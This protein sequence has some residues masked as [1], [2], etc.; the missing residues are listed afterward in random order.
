M[1]N[2]IRSTTRTRCKY[3]TTTTPA[4][5][6]E[7]NSE[8]RNPPPVPTSN[9]SLHSLG[10][11][12]VL[13]ANKRRSPARGPLEPPRA[14]IARVLIKRLPPLR[15]KSLV[16]SDQ[17][18]SYFVQVYD[19]FLTHDWRSISSYLCSSRGN[20]KGRLSLKVTKDSYQDNTE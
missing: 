16:I 6:L 18:N 14:A 2:Q 3:P 19:E 15:G 10:T 12:V 4:T 11:A 1:S 8:R 5:N 7:N 20:F 17:G 9:P 13:P